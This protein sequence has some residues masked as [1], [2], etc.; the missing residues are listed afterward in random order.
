MVMRI[1]SLNSNQ[2]TI[3]FN[4]N[5]LQFESRSNDLLDSRQG[6]HLATEVNKTLE[7][8]TEGQAPVF[9]VANK[10]AGVVPGFAIEDD[11][12]R[13]DTVLQITAEHIRPPYHQN[14]GFIL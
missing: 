7:S 13:L 5:I 2:R 9:I 14:P 3:P 6:N 10:I 11:K 8:P 1:I 12:G 4:R